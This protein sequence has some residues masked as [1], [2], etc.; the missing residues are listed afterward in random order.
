MS[1]QLRW[2]DF[3]AEWPPHTLRGERREDR[4]RTLSASFHHRRFTFYGFSPE[5]VVTNKSRTTN[6]QLYDY[7]KNSAELRFVRQF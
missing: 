4:T 5:L 3:E 1:G 6:A 2:T 7:R